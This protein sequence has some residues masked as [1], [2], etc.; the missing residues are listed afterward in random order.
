MRNVL[1]TCGMLVVTG[2][3]ALLTGCKADSPPATSSLGPYSAMVNA[4]PKKVAAAVMLAAAD[5]HLTD[6]V[7]NVTDVAGKVTAKTRAGDTVTV[8]IHQAGDNT[9]SLT[10]FVDTSADDGVSMQLQL[11]EKVN[12][13]LA[14]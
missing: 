9:S 14:S 5:L 11:A 4:E 12:L 3:V 8:G 13:H 6:I 1:L 10:I 7:A 2:V